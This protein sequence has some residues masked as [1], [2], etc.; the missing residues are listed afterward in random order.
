MHEVGAWI[1]HWRTTRRLSQAEL[2]ADAEISARHLSCLE[3]GK[4]RPSR[5]MLLVLCSALDVPLA[6]RNE[7]LLAGGFAPAYRASRIRRS[8]R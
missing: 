7:A 4:A 5:E 8:V 2:A 3:T 1:R 6:D